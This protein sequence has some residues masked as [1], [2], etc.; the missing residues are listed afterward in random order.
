MENILEVKNLKKYYNDIKAVDDISFAVRKGSFFAFLGENGAGKSTTIKCITTLKSADSGTISLNQHTD[1]AY[2]KE[3]V[4]V[5]FQENVLDD[6][7]SVKENLLTRG[8][9]YIQDKKLLNERYQHLVI[10]LRLEELE[11]RR[12][13]QLS[14]GQKRRVEI[15]RALFASPSLLILDEPTTGLDPETRRL[16]WELINDLQRESNLTVFLTTHYMEEAANADYIVI[17]DEGKIVAEGSPSE[18]K[19]KYSHDKLKIV[20]EDKVSLVE[21]LE[22]NKLVYEKIADQYQVVVS[23]HQQALTILFD[24]TINIKSFEFVNGTMDDVFLEVVGK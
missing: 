8:S 16:V 23:D 17:I 2:I 15:A 10:K 19:V 9:L 1:P 7:L 5:V 18:L 20:P 22:Q 3:H 13:G 12:F 4:G 6:M 11:S 24:Q 21:Y 14:G